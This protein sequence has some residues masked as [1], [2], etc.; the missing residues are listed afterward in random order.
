MKMPKISGL[1][2]IR[3][4]RDNFKDIGILMIT[5]YPS[6]GSAVE[7]V[8]LGADDYLA[9]PFTKS[10][11]LDAVQAVLAKQHQ[12]SLGNSEPIAAPAAPSGIIGASERMRGIFEAIE[13][14]AAV[15]ANVLISG[16]SGTGK[17]LVARA[18]HYKSSRVSHP[19]VPVNCGGIPESLLESE[20]FGHVKGSFTGATES[21][22][23][24][25]QTA[26][27]GSIFLDEV[28][29][30]SL[31]MQVKLLRVLQEKEIC[32]VGSAKPQKVDVRIIAGTNKNL[33]DLIKSGRF[34]EDLYYRLHVIHIVLPPLRERGDDVLLLIRHF[35]AKYAQEMGKPRPEYTDRTLSIL[36][37]YPWPGNV[38]ELENLVQRLMAMTEGDIIDAP[39]LPAG[40]RSECFAEERGLDRTL[41]QVEAEYVRHVLEKV[42]GNKSRAAKILGIDR[43]TLREK[44]KRIGL[45]DWA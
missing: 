28:S 34:R 18:I 41:E 1:D 25:F 7:A 5:G 12:R 42:K 3:H 4:I 38:R 9:K 32:M 24:F 14:A 35:S 36:R 6:I 13:K 40:I 19:F 23:G 30:T 10:E 21:R 8:R 11:L 15:K 20:L 44:L 22:A 16:E 31:T 29:E 27:R 17:E 26:H 45:T 39:D 33:Q 37:D 43:K 2:L